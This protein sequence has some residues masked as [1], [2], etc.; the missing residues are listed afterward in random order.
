MKNQAACRLH[1]LLTELTAGG[2]ASEMTVN[3]ANSL[4]EQVDITDAVARQRV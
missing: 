3:K 4:L 2:L 1:T